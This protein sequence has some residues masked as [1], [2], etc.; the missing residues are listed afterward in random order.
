VLVKNVVALGA[1][2]GVTEIF[3]KETF[4]A[5]IRKAVSGKRAM[6]TINE[7]AFARGAQLAA[8][9]NA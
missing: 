6:L 5:A 4:L 8:E 1:L 3:P 7:Q 9:L 2:Q